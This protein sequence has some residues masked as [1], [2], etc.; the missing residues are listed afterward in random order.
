MNKNSNKTN[1]NALWLTL[2]RVLRLLIG[3]VIGIL[4]A[5]YLGPE[6][7]GIIS[8][9]QAI[10]ILIMP[11]TSFGLQELVIREYTNFPNK[12]DIIT[13]NYLFSRI[14]LSTFFIITFLAIF[15]IYTEPTMTERLVMSFLLLSLVPQSFDII[16]GSFQSDNK[17]AFAIIAR[18]F[19]LI[20]M[21]ILRL[22]LISESKP[23]EYFAASYIFETVLYA[24]FMIMFFRKYGISKF[25][26]KEIDIVFIILSIKNSYLIMIRMLAIG[27]YIRIDQIIVEYYLGSKGI[28]IYSASSRISEIWYFLPVALATAST[29]RLAALYRDDRNIFDQS[30]QNNLRL[31]LLIALPVTLLISIFSEQIILFTFGASFIAAADVLSLQVWAGLFV[32]LGS[33]ASPWFIITNR[34]GL[35]VVQAVIGAASAMLICIV[36]IPKIGMIGG[37]ISILV[38]NLF[39]GVLFNAVLK[40]TRPLFMMQLRAFAIYKIRIPTF[41][42][43]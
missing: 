24:L 15:E 4:V 35:G 9:A 31:I 3:F 36:L 42:I 43:K 32:A 20:I 41:K 14:V 39:S 38:S 26:V 1:I 27:V 18:T 5:R 40:D 10:M 19:S 8:Y 2:D 30:I 29:P 37:A 16:E 11:L 25:R 6:N 23:I 22:W 34:L 17:F 12:L 33:V 28:G 21:S 13:T 7:F